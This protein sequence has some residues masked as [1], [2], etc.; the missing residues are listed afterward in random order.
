MGEPV[1]MKKM[2][3]SLDE[4]VDELEFL[5]STMAKSIVDH[6]ADIVIGR[7]VSPT[8]F[9]AFE[10]TCREEEAGS[11]VGK[12]GANAEAIR[13]LLMAAAAARGIRVTVQLMSAQGG[14][15]RR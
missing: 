13:S 3:K 2:K 14:M 12:R 9:V 6:P 4:A 7:A 8:G 11:L 5:L 1:P 15:A 10:V